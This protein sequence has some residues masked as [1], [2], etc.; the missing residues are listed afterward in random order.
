MHPFQQRL[1][2]LLASVD[3]L[4][5]GRRQRLSR[6]LRQADIRCWER[7]ATDGDDAALLAC[8][9]TLAHEWLELLAMHFEAALAACTS[10]EAQLVLAAVAARET[11]LGR[12]VRFHVSGQLLGGAF[13]SPVCV[14]LTPGADPSAADLTI[15]AT[16]LPGKISKTAQSLQ[17]LV[18]CRGQESTFHSELVGDS[19]VV[20]L[21]PVELRDD[22]FSAAA[23]LGA[24]VAQALG[25][26][27]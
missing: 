5:D 3:G 12:Q 26:L 2:Q 22:P 7:P 4:S 1:E 24:I 14:T 11:V 20:R 16:L 10:L 21:S 8:T 9:R 17:I 18:Y 6:P 19:A 15:D 25:E 23:R 27:F 13:P